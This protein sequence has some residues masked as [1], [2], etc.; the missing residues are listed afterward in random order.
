MKSLIMLKVIKPPMY[1]PVHAG[2][3]TGAGMGQDGAAD[4]CEVRDSV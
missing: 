4:L 1:E 3:I 2:Q